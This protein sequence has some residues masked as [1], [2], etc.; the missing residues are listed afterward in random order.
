[1]THWRLAE[2]A[3]IARARAAGIT[4]DRSRA[5]ALA[6]HAR[7]V[8]ERNARLHLTTVVSPDEVLERHVGEGF[9]AA[10]LL[11]DA[12]DGP[13]LDLGSGNGYP[14]LV[15]AAARPGLFPVLAESNGRKAAF[16]REA[17]AVAAIPGRVLER[18]VQRAADLEGERRFAL[19]VTRAAG[20]WERIVPKLLDALAQGGRV[21]IF[22]GEGLDAVLRRAAW[23]R[24][25]LEGLREM[26][27]R[28]HSRA[29]L[30]SLK[31]I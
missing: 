6:A 11:D 1:V 22:A 21:L 15:I 26:P 4:L 31:S 8:I 23:R 18:S 2:E 20:G 17:L 12:I 10:A 3:I 14:G 24:L 16:L 19:L 29:A 5:A 25:A 27:G 30:L 7:L 28:R 13:L 9:E